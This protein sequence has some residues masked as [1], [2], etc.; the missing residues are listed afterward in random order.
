M[1]IPI[2]A[3]GDPEGPLYTPRP[4]GPS[5]HHSPSSALKYKYASSVVFL[6][7]A[8]SSPPFSFF[9]VTSTSHPL[10]THTAAN[11]A[12]ISSRGF[13]TYS[14]E[15]SGLASANTTIFSAAEGRSIRENVGVELKGVS[16]S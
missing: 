16:W 13:A 4:S 5:I 3:R 12:G 10:S 8:P 2:G 11:A 7:H 14:P 6:N 9:Q 15:T 1:D